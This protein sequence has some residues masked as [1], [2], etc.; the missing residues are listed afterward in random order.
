[1]A[2]STALSVVVILVTGWLHS[3]CRSH[4]LVGLNRLPAHDRKREE[5]EIGEA[6]AKSELI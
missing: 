6:A 5:W 3:R 2:G 1:M 4:L